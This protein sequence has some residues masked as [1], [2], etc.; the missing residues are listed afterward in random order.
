[1]G[2]G[3]STEEE[4][5]T[6]RHRHRPSTGGSTICLNEEVPMIQDIL[7]KLNFLL[8]LGLTSTQ[9]LPEEEKRMLE[10]AT[11]IRKIYDGAVERQKRSMA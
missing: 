10:L 2:E 8:A 3:Q 9:L 11:Q 1:M 7:N 6:A 5:V 4:E